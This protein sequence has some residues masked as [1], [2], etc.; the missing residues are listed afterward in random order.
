MEDSVMEICV[1][2]WASS[3][4]KKLLSLLTSQ[5]RN[6]FNHVRNSLLMLFLI[7]RTHMH[8]HVRLKPAIIYKNLQKTHCVTAQ[9][10]LTE[11]VLH[12]TR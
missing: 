10:L 4:S 12:Q 5:K 1:S 11:N 8:L 3:S 7:Y 9:S 6:M 2:I